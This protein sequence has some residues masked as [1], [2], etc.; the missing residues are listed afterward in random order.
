M[1]EIKTNKVEIK[2]V[3]KTTTSI[4]LFLHVHIINTQS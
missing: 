1:E 3:F 4:Y 2:M